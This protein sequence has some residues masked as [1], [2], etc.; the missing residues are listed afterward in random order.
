MTDFTMYNICT[1]HI[2]YVYAYV[3]TLKIADILAILE[4]KMAA[5]MTLLFEVYNKYLNR[6][7][8]LI[9]YCPL[10][11]TDPLIYV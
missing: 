7:G 3:C 5:I 8:L 9:I 11:I 2:I 10:D 4:Y 6:R 1:I